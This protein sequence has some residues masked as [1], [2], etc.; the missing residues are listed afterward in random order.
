LL[1]DEDELTAALR[2][3]KLPSVTPAEVRFKDRTRYLETSELA[4]GA[5]LPLKLPLLL[6]IGKPLL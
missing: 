3:R 1:E 4:L 6:L 5:L 2:N